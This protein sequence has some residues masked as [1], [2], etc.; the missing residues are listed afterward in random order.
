MKTIVLLFFILFVL[1]CGSPHA[2]ELGA[3]P[4]DGER[5]KIMEETLLRFLDQ[6]S[7]PSPSV[8]TLSMKISP[9]I[10]T[11][12]ILRIPSGSSTTLEGKQITRFLAVTPEKISIEQKSPSSLIVT[13]KTL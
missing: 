11:V 7:A 3:P 6:G 13:G 12:E 9:D 10:S 4:F 2:K 8:S 5:E 1:L